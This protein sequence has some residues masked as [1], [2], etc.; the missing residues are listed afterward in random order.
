[1]YLFTVFSNSRTKP[2]LNLTLSFSL[3]A[4][5][6]YLSSLVCNCIHTITYPPTHFV[7]QYGA[8]A[9]QGL[10]YYYP[11]YLQKS[12][13]Q[14][15]SRKIINYG[16]GPNNTVVVEKEWDIKNRRK[17]SPLWKYSKNQYDFERPDCKRV[18]VGLCVPPYNDHAH[19]M[20]KDLK[21]WKNLPFSRQD[22]WDTTAKLTA[23]R[24]W[25]QTVGRLKEDGINSATLLSGAS[26]KLRNAIKLGIF[27]APLSVE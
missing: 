25:W 16:P 15:M 18:T 5:G 14:I 27:E 26:E 20:G 11:K 9:D 4:A 7:V 10:L 3:F 24:L 6:L 17:N 19:F 13:T 2:Q 21:P 23:T 22:L 8:Y 12:M 1:M